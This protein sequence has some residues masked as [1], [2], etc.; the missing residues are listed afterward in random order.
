MAKNKINSYECRQYFQHSTLTFI[1]QDVLD[2]G[3]KKQ[4]E[5]A[6]E[7]AKIW[8]QK[9]TELG[10][11]SI[12]DYFCHKFKNVTLDRQADMQALGR[13]RRDYFNVIKN[14][15]Q[16][17]EIFNIFF[18]DRLLEDDKKEKY[19]VSSERDRSVE[20]WL[21]RNGEGYDL[22]IGGNGGVEAPEDS[23]YL[24]ASY[25]NVKKILLKKNINTSKV[26]NMSRMFYGCSC[27][28]ELEVGNFDT[29]NAKDMSW[30][31]YG[32]N[33]LQELDIRN[34]D[35]GNVQ[36]MSRM[37]SGCNHLQELDI[38]NFD[39]SNVQN[40]SWMFHDCSRLKVLD[41]RSFDTSNVE[42]TL[43]MFS[44]CNQLQKLDVR[45]FNVSNIKNMS[46]MFSGCCY[47]DRFQGIEQLK[48]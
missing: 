37:F 2:R 28:Q 17:K 10:N 39:T 15:V 45:N 41:V 26:Q 6:A 3:R 23:S 11:E 33:Q 22:Y 31:F 36:N 34:F 16:K 7:L 44:L 25:K 19:D 30:M 32:C 46:Y 12:Q 38:R 1:N 13:L 47:I 29:S 35:T 27:L 5:I 40:M 43:G 48:K 14:R 9:A 42:E 8:Y 20:L 21:E 18:E 4:G 24:F